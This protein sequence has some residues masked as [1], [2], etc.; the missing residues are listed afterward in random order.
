MRWHEEICM[1]SDGTPL[2]SEN[3]SVPGAIAADDIA[4]HGGKHHYRDEV[5]TPHQAVFCWNKGSGGEVFYTIRVTGG[6]R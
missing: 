1:F 3:M 2:L 4:V 5:P 6:E